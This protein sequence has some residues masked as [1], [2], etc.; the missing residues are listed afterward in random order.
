MIPPEVGQQRVWECEGNHDTPR[1]QA[2]AG[3]RARKPMS[4]PQEPGGSGYES[5]KKNAIP[6]EA[7]RRGYESAKETMIPPEVRQ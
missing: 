3:M 1:S 5:E 2:A 7:N 4:Y 6:A